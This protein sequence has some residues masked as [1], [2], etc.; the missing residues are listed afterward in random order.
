MARSSQHVEKAD[1]SAVDIDRSQAAHGVR[2]RAHALRHALDQVKG[3]V[4]A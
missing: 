2:E 4:G 1:Q 3:Q